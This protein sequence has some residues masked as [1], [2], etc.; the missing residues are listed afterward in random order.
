MAQPYRAR[1]VVAG[2]PVRDLAAERATLAAQHAYSCRAARIAGGGVAVL[3]SLGA[4]A[5]GSLFH[6]LRDFGSALL[7][8]LFTGV[9]SAA[10]Y[11]V[12]RVAAGREARAWLD[13]PFVPSTDAVADLVRLETS[14]PL[15]VFQRRAERAEPWS[16]GFPLLAMSLILPLPLIPGDTSFILGFENLLYLLPHVTLAVCAVFYAR[17]VRRSPSTELLLRGQRDWSRA[18]LFTTLATAPGLLRMLAQA[19]TVRFM[20]AFFFLGLLYLPT[21]LLVPAAFNVLRAR[22]VRE[23]AVFARLH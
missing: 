13:L 23:R 22:V 1:E 18:L 6:E 11:A 7:V 2:S 14:S 10:G 16:V 3:S 4:F 17:L 12:V 8:M 9:V 20:G 15:R 21:V 5:E 19:G